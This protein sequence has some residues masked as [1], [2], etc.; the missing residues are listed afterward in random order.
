MKIKSVEYSNRKRT[1]EVFTSR[2]TFEFP[3]AK[4]RPQPKRGNYVT[5]VSVDKEL[6][7]EAFTY[8]LESGRE[9]S[10]HID[11]VLEYNQDPEHMKDLLLYNLTVAVHERLEHSPVTKRELTRRLDTS[12]SQLYRLLDPA[13]HQKS[14]GQLLTILHLLDCDVAL[15]IKDRKGRQLV[16]CVA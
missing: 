15:V 13:N 4:T 11:H 6:G 1:F 5:E 16:E 7:K 9:G 2:G 12:A 14:I 8:V 10:V 3:Y